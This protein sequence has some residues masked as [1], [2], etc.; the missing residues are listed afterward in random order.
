[1]IE[2]SR[3]TTVV[4]DLGNVLVRW[5]PRAVWTGARADAE[6]TSFLDESSFRVLNHAVDAGMPI[7][8]AVAT[9]RR[10]SPDH[11]AMLE[12]YFAGFARSLPGP[13]PGAASLVDDLQQ[14]GIRLLG[15][16]NWSAE[17]YHHAAVAA[18]AIAALES[19]MVSGRERLAKPEPAIFHR[20]VERYR[21]VPEET[22]FADDTPANVHAAREVGLHAH[23]VTSTAGLRS[24]LRELGVE[25]PAAGSGDEG[26][27][28]AS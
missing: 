14:A 28:S 7:V 19:V 22:V 9:M 23:H 12:E 3:I 24:R 11:A 20:L 6:V 21:L 10:E 4:L 15:L 13:V 26:T 17:T 18:P 1:M 27:A 5:D 2:G 25:I 8:D 16:T